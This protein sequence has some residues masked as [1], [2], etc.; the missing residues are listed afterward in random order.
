[1]KAYL[2]LEDGTI[3]KGR[4]FGAEGIKFGEVVFTTAMVGYPESL[5]DPS[6]RGQILI[7]THPLIGNYGVPSKE[8]RENGIPLHYESDKIQVEGYV[9][10]RLMRPS[11]W[12]SEMGLDE[13]LKKEGIPGM[14]GVDT[15][16][17]V[18]KIREKGVMM[19]ALVVGDYE[20]EDLEEIMKQIR[21]LSYDRIN[22]VDEVTPKDI[23]I[24]EPKKV[25][26]TV[27]VVDCGIK[28]GIL[29]ELL[30]RNLRVVRIP[31]TYDPIKAFEEFNASGIV[32]SNGPG[33]PSL[34][35]TLV[36]N[37]KAIIEYN[38]P[39]MGIC[40]GHQILALADGAEIYKLKYGHRGINKP[41]KDLKTGKA[42]VT[43]QNHGYAIKPES[44]NEFRVWMINL[45]DRS[46]EGIY[47][48]NK[49]IIAT[50][51]HPEASPGPLD[52]TWIFDLFAKLIRGG[53]HGF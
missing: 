49:P 17:L 15:R 50:Q 29:R 2:L 53:V 27:V 36:E 30:K 14:E 31:Y 34:L 48:P 26:R 46:V 24:H 51:F 21:K 44:L 18:K 20:K 32:L 19:G 38:V 3:I 39:T 43:T 40:L 4:G 13:W 16:A 28:Y 42:F 35:K 1:M 6:Y 11:H 37:A 23:I 52:S 33:N 8:I 12:A 25:D 41:V 10:S 22:F 7:M 47:H 45:D 9:I 5:T